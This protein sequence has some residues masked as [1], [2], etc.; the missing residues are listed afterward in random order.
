MYCKIKRPD[1]AKYP[2]E[3]GE[4]IVIQEKLDGSNLVFFK[5]NDELYFAQRKTIINI[6]ELKERGKALLGLI[7][8]LFQNH[9]EFSVLLIQHSGIL[10]HELTSIIQKLDTMF[11]LLPLIITNAIALIVSLSRILHIVCETSN[12]LNNLNDVF[13]HVHMDLLSEINMYWNFSIKEYVF[14]AK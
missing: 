7:P 14:F 4:N 5:K 2:I 13:L 3:K 11:D 8:Q 1:N 9:I 10:P 12:V 6:N